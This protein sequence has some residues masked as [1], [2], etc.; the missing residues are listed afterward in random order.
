MTIELRWRSTT[1]VFLPS[2]FAHRKHDSFSCAGTF[3][4]KYRP[5]SHL[6]LSGFLPTGHGLGAYSAPEIDRLVW[7]VEGDMGRVL[8]II[9]S[10]TGM[11]PARFGPSAR[12]ST[13]T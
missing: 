13:P 2:Y 5:R 11:L 9:E 6:V 8:E 12:P 4:R 7:V 3:R 10:C 1:L